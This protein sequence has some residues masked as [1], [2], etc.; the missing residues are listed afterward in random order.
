[1]TTGLP[2]P[3]QTTRV[4]RVAEWLLQALLD[5]RAREAVIGDLHEGYHVVRRD[6]GST[7][8]RWWYWRHAARSV[9]ACRLTGHRQ[10]DARRFDF[11]PRARVSLRDLVRPALRQFR[12][13][14]LYHSP[15]QGHSRSRS[16]R[17]V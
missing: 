3:Q 17:P 2:S 6:R 14:P 15:V 5:E 16:V 1:M 12:D 9:I 11:D 7:T 4:P 8:A 10:P 13:Q